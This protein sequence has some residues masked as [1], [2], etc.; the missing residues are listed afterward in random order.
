MGLEDLNRLMEA[1]F[2]LESAERADAEVILWLLPACWGRIEI[3]STACE[4]RVD[5][6]D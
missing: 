5:W 6:C 1:I 3:Q 2:K 4:S